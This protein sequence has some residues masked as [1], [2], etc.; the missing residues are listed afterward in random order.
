MLDIIVLICQTFGSNLSFGEFGRFPAMHTSWA[1][2]LAGALAEMLF[3]P[4]LKGGVDE[5]VNKS[6]MRSDWA[7]LNSGAASRNPDG[8]GE[9]VLKASFFI[10]PSLLLIH[11]MI[12]FLLKSPCPCWGLPLLEKHSFHNPIPAEIYRSWEN[13]RRTYLPNYILLQTNWMAFG[14]NVWYISQFW[15]RSNIQ[16]NRILPCARKTFGKMDGSNH[17]R[18]R[19][20][21]KPYD[22]FFISSLS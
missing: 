16:S 17:F 11:R 21:K 7:D 9:A 15:I 12:L 1:G 10:S 5:W 20:K 3:F 14:T 2:P 18:D 13:T 4:A 22:E 8:W 6:W 19:Y